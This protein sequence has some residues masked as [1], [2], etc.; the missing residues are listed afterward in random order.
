MNWNVLEYITSEALSANM[1]DAKWL[2]RNDIQMQAKI[3]IFTIPY[4]PTFKELPV[5]GADYI[6]F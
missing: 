1:M 4:F 2:S 5:H 6:L 3:E